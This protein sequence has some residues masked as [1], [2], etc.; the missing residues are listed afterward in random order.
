MLWV[1][2]KILPA[3]DIGASLI[4]RVALHPADRKSQLH[5]NPTGIKNPSDLLHCW[6]PTN[7]C[8]LK[9]PRI[10]RLRSKQDYSQCNLLVGTPTDGKWSDD[11]TLI[12]NR[13]PTTPCFSLLFQSAGNKKPVGFVP[14]SSG[15]VLLSI[16][17]VSPTIVV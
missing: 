2:I 8:C 7:N 10:E 13:R 9:L 3:F 17:G 11:Y 1:E 14:R 5:F 15:F 16:V 12:R 6:C 4:R